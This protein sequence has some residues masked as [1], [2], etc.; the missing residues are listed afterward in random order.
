MITADHAEKQRRDGTGATATQRVL[1][2]AGDAV[3]CARS[4][5][6][7]DAEI[8][9]RTGTVLAHA[10]APWSAR[11]GCPG[12]LFAPSRMKSGLISVQ[13]AATCLFR[14]AREN[15]RFKGMGD[16]PAPGHRGPVG[17][18]NS[19]SSTVWVI[20]KHAFWCVVQPFRNQLSAAF[21][22]GLM[23][24]AQSGSSSTKCVASQ[25]R[26]AGDGRP[27]CCMRRTIRKPAQSCKPVLRDPQHV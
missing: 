24:G 17:T 25:V 10:M 9:G 18:M 2:H 23:P 27:G 20:E 3:N 12:H 15:G 1:P 16:A 26:G 5:D 19:A 11:D 8:G 13:R 4:F 21:F 6:W 22:A 14:W 7:T